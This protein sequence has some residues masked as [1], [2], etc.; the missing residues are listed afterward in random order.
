MRKTFIN[1]LNLV[2]KEESSTWRYKI[3]N[4]ILRNTEIWMFP[5]QRM[6]LHS[7]RTESLDLAI[8]EHNSNNIN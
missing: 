1:K 4:L 2:F 6:T 7:V 5:L 8:K 3:L